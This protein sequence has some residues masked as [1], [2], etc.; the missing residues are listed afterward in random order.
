MTCKLALASAEQKNTPH[1]S[2]VQFF[3]FQN[4]RMTIVRIYERMQRA[5]ISFSPA[6][7]ERSVCEKA[8]RLRV[9]MGPTTG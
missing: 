7:R 9:R 2:P 5:K 6:E 8:H 1:V 3:S 4:H